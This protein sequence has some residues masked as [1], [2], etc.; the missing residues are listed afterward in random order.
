MTDGLRCP[1]CRV[2]L[3]AGGTPFGAVHGCGRCDGASLGLSVLRHMAR[4]RSVDALWIEV[5]GAPV[6]GGAACPSC[7]NPMRTVELDAGA[8]PLVL[9]GCASCQ[10]IW[11]DAGEVV[12]FA[13]E[14]DRPRAAEPDMSPRAREALAEGAVAARMDGDALDAL[15]SWARRGARRRG[16]TYVAPASPPPGAF[17]WLAQGLLWF[18]GR[19]P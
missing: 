3:E 5:R 13:P 12:R 10:L 14:R 7:A 4:K 15:A 6:R 16:A 19:A 8:A 9:D 17:G 1:R 2:P 18:G 11:F